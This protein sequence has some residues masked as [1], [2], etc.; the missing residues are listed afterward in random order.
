MKKIIILLVSAFALCA[1]NVYA[2]NSEK[3]AMSQVVSSPEKCEFSLDKYVGTVKDGCTAAIV[4]GLNCA[5]PKDVSATVYVY[6]DNDLV[7]SKIFTIEKGMTYSGT[8]GSKIALE[9]EYNGK[10]YTLK[11]R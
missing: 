7:A 9:E 1:S 4:V 2:T 8:V 10:K 5:Q 11:V 3:P 6:I